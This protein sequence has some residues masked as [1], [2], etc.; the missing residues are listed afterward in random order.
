M[1]LNP[2]HN[3]PVLVDGDL[4]LNESRAICVYIAQK[5]DKTGKLYPSDIKTQARVNQMLNFDSGTL[6]HR[7]IQVFVSIMM[8]FV[9][10]EVY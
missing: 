1:Q 4:V 6:F 10:E 8:Q 2:Q 9:I 3:V 5:Y 7:F